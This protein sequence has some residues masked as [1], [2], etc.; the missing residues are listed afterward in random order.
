MIYLS[1]LTSP[2]TDSCNETEQMMKDEVLILVLA[3]LV[4]RSLCEEFCQKGKVYEEEDC[5]EEKTSDRF[6]KLTNG[7]K[8]P[9]I[10]FGTWKVTEERDIF[11]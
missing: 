10:G 9:E 4:C 5:S 1:S 8:M 11:I 6:V 7:V 2:V 3:V